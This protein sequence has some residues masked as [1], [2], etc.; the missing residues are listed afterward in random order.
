MCSSIQLTKSF[1]VSLGAND[2]PQIETLIIEEFIQGVESRQQTSEELNILANVTKILEGLQ[3]N[4][5]KQFVEMATQQCSD[6]L[7]YVSKVF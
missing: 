4:G 3:M 2:H 1:L 7:I 6:L 5:S